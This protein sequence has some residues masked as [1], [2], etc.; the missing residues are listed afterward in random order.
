[1]SD[2]AKESA[3]EGARARLEAA[4]SGLAQGVASSKN[5]LELAK[6]SADEKLALAERVSTLEQENLK[7]HEQVA[8][9]ALQTPATDNSEQIAILEAEKAAIEGN[10]QLLKQQYSALEDEIE[11]GSAQN[12]D[13]SASNAENTRLKQM[14]SEM[15]QEKSAVR[16]ELDKTILELEAI[17]EGA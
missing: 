9:Y 12:G 3:L 16:D 1:M 15:E 2:A 13:A 11:A 17:V 10:Y 14:I 7:L 5:A 6:T 4:L 8:A